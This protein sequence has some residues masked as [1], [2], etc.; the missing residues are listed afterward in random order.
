MDVLTRYYVHKSNQIKLIIY[1]NNFY[2][3]IIIPSPTISLSIISITVQIQV[4][5]YFHY[6]IV[7]IY[8]YFRQLILIFIYIIFLVIFCT[9]AAKRLW[10]EFFEFFKN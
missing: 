3:F 1:F 5:V 6:F 10:S 9:L 4:T 7:T 8:H 2:G